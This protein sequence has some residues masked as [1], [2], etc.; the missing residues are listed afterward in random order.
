[1]ES[2]PFEREIFFHDDGEVVVTNRRVVVRGE[3]I[4]TRRLRGSRA[5]TK[6]RGR[7]IQIIG[8]V[9]IAATFGL[10]AA[11]CSYGVRAVEGWLYGIGSFSA[12]CLGVP[13][14]LGGL[15][16]KDR[17]ELHLDID[18]VERVVFT[19]YNKPLMDMI[20][21][22]VLHARTGQVQYALPERPPPPPGVVIGYAPWQLA[23]LAQQAPP[24]PTAWGT[25]RWNPA[26]NWWFYGEAPYPVPRPDARPRLGFLVTITFFTLLPFAM[27]ALPHFGGDVIR[28]LF[29]LKRPL[30]VIAMPIVAFKLWWSHNAWSALPPECRT[31]STGRRLTVREV[32]WRFFFPLYGLYWG[33]LVHV[34]VVEAT[35]AVL[36]SYGSTER[37]RPLFA[38]L[39]CIAVLIPGVNLLSPW[40]LAVHMFECDRAQAKML[41]LLAHGP[42][43]V[44]PLGPPR[45]PTPLRFAP[46]IS[47]GLVAFELVALVVALQLLVYAAGR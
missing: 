38:W 22:A 21:L 1:M 10:G 32:S 3:T 11:S 40:L 39:A 17:F 24:L 8:I 25:P 14:F 9:F 36:A 33:F 18:G 46:W 34:G 35:N 13:L 16:A 7:A 20:D 2:A 6:I 30:F 44:A 41:E 42:P 29:N 47:F 23:Q 28:F 26:W 43:T 12:F 15:T 27:I 5:E 19:T 31:T 45:P 37:A 4:E